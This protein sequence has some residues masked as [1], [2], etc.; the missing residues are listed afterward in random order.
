[1]WAYYEGQ[2]SFEVIERDDGWIGVSGGAPAYFRE[3]KDWSAHEKQAMQYVHGRVLDV[4]A[5][6]G[7]VS[8]CLQE[9][10]FDVTAIEA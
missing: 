6:A 1:M 5:G 10:G 7:R 2:D 4:G 3:F 8:L 9:Q